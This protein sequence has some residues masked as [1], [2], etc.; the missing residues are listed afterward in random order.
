MPQ[1]TAVVRP[2]I[3]ASTED[4]YKAPTK[5]ILA[6]N[7]GMNIEK[8]ES[9][10]KTGQ[11]NTTEDKSSEAVTL[12]P[13]LTAL[14]R[15]EQKFRQEQQAFKSREKEFEAKQAEYAAFASLKDKLTSKDFSVLDELGVSYEEWTNYLLNKGETSNPETQ[16]L[17][18]LE[19]EVKSIK[20]QQ[21]DNV[22]KQYEA[23]VNQYRK[24]IKVLVEKD[25][26]YESIK[27]LKAEEHVLQH[28]LDTF[29]EDG[30]ALSIEDASKEIEDFLVEEALQMAKLKKVQ[31][32]LIPDKKTLPPPKTGL[33][34]LTQS[35]AP[36][37]TKTYQQSQHLSPKERIAQAIAKSQK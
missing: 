22:N 31:E 37:S 28:I 17:K 1:I 24:D 13:Q 25:P 12:S 30:E 20:S 8:P 4:S 26:A 14:A 15:K 19:D 23:T 21:V 11:L 6:A 16:A 34:T 5:T 32:K 7:T 33:R 18:K 3:A 36:S 35:I 29:N 2:T 9:G 10:A 27:E